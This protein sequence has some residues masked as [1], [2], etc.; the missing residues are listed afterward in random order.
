MNGEGFP[1][2]ED[3]TK[4]VEDIGLRFTAEEKTQ[5]E[6]E[7]R[8]D[9]NGFWMQIIDEDVKE[10]ELEKVFS[11]FDSDG[12]GFIS[13]HELEALL[14]KIGFWESS[15][16]NCTRMIMAYDTNSDGKIDFDEFKS[17]IKPSL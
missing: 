11:V 4:V 6:E 10:Q 15:C 12:D 13:S 1:S 14:K 16:M 5:L 8:F 3:L 9:V 2:L 17:M 7:M